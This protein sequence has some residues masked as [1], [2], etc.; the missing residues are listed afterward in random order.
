M[1]ALSRFQRVRY[2]QKIEVGFPPKEVNFVCHEM[3]EDVLLKYELNNNGR[4]TF[5]SVKTVSNKHAE[6]LFMS[7]S[8]FG[9][10]YLNYLIGDKVVL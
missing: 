10:L 3:Y 9:K 6:V 2:T 4:S 5:S 1:F 7:R 8:C